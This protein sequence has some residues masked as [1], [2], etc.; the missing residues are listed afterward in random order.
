MMELSPP[1]A[2]R[3]I[4]RTLEEAGFETWAVGGAV[5]DALAGIPSGDWD[6]T[7]SARPGQIRR[8]FPRTVPI[9]VEHGT[10]GILARDGTLFEVTTFRRDVQTTGRHAV[11]AFS[12]SL[13]ED[14]ARRDFT[15]NAVAWHPLRKVMY[16]PFSGV[17]D[18]EARCLQTVGEARVRFAE[19]YLRILRALRFAGVFQL[20]VTSETWSALVEAVPRMGQLSAERI[21]EEMEKILTG[22]AQPS[23]SLSLYAASG[24]L[25]FF[26]P[27]LDRLVGLPHPPE[28]RMWD[29]DD[30]E[31]RVDGHGQPHEYGQAHENDREGGAV[32]SGDVWSHALRTVDLLPR[33]RPALRWAA[34]LAGIGIPEEDQGAG[35]VGE[36]EGRRTLLRS[37]AVLRRL[38]SSNARIQEVGGLA[39]WIGRP[40]DP[41]ASDAGLRRW[42]S[43]VGRDRLPDLLRIWIAEARSDRLLRAAPEK[44]PQGWKVE[45]LR[46]LARRLRGLSSMEFPLSTGELAF[47]GRDLIRMGHRPGPHFGQLL[48][49][50]LE[51]VLQDP[52]LNT[53]EALTLEAKRWMKDWEA[54]EGASAEGR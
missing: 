30:G 10:V 39:E 52:E 46:R 51:M 2:V 9:G 45:E 15:I 36:E 23:T 42:L 40:P 41:S 16:D 50:L 22:H 35:E 48:D 3:W 26:Y 18:M 1:G 13:D 24:V 47:S 20:T 14:L 34:L 54:R 17:A 31:A 4:C 19:D 8:I 5:R 12:D 32:R 43:Q 21:R 28:T 27:E 6:L 38:R 44:G 11:V 53:S 49:H 7:T 33:H 25:A 37:A 29:V